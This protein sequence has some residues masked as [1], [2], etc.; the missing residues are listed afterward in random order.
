[1]SRTALL[2]PFSFPASL[3]KAPKCLGYTS[4]K[5]GLVKSC[6]SSKALFRFPLVQ[7]A[8][9]D[10]LISFIHSFNKCT[11]SYSSGPD[12]VPGTGHEQADMFPILVQSV[13]FSGLE[14]LVVSLLLISS[15]YTAS[16]DMG[17]IPG[18]RRSPGGGNGNPLQYSCLENSI[19]RGSR[20]AIVHQVAKSQTQLNMYAGIS[21]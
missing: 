5:L 6:P 2:W 17:S 7:E 14:T 18:L 20:Q 3:Y 10:Y 15:R 13:E 9:F 8:F 21:Q 1:M 19:D 11:L 16:G 12:S 4:F